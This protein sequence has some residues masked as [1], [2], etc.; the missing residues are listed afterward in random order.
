MWVAWNLVEL[1]WSVTT[2]GVATIMLAI[3]SIRPTPTDEE[4]VALSKRGDGHAFGDLVERYQDRIYSLCLRWLGQPLVAEEVAQD[5]FMS[6]WRALPRFRHEARFDT[7][8]RRI[9]VNKCKNRRLYDQRRARDKHDS[10]QSSE[11]DD[12][13]AALQLVHGGPGSDASYFQSEASKLLQRALA[14]ISEEHRAIILLRDLEDLSYDEIAQQ[15]DVPRGT[16]KSRLHRARG[17][18]ATV[19]STQCGREDVF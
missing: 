11:E 4:L 18:L 7:W 14:E 19:L 10:I 5:V 13:R 9:A 2:H 8:L 3:A 16:V 1:P 6:A 15:L 17:V 12:D